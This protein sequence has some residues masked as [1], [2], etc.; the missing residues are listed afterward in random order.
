[1]ISNA[2]DHRDRAQG[3]AS[4]EER[5]AGAEEAQAAPRGAC[6]LAR[7]GGAARAAGVVEDDVP[8][9]RHGH[10]EGAAGG[11]VGGAGVGAGAAGAP[12]ASSREGDLYALPRASL[13][14]RRRR[15]WSTAACTAPASSPESS[16]RRSS[17]ACRCTGR[18]RPSTARACTSLA[19]RWSTCTTG[20]ASLIE[21]L[22]LT[23]AR[24]GAAEPHRLRRR[25][26]AQ[27][28]AGQEARLHLDLR[29]R[30]GRRLRLQPRRAGET[31]SR[32]LGDSEGVLVV[33]GYTGYNQVTLPGRRQRAGCNAHARRKFRDIEHP[34]ARSVIEHYKEVFAVERE[35][36]ERG[37]VGTPE[38]LEL[39]RA[40]A[41]PA[42][43][44]IRQIVDDQH[45]RHGPK[46]PMGKAIRYAR[47]QWEY[48]TRFLDDVAIEPS[49]NL[50]ERLLRTVA[51]GRKNYL[52]V[53]HE[54]AGPQHRHARLGRADMRPPRRRPRRPTS[55]TSSSASRR[56]PCPRST[57][58]CRIAGR[59]SSP[60][61]LGEGRKR[62]T[63]PELSPQDVVCRSDSE[64]PELRFRL[65]T[66]RLS[67]LQPGRRERLP[68]GSPRSFGRRSGA[69]SQPGGL[70][71]FSQH[72]VK[73]GDR[74]PHACSGKAASAVGEHGRHVGGGGVSGSERPPAALS[75][76]AWRVRPWLP[77]Q[78][79]AVP[80]SPRGWAPS[81]GSEQHVT[82]DKRHTR[83]QLEGSHPH[84]RGYVAYPGRVVR[85]DLFHDGRRFTRFGPEPPRHDAPKQATE[86]E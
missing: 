77:H 70:R 86:L 65:P 75:Q 80:W 76:T 58:S 6:G 42:M 1:M 51:L 5:R 23:D 84:C 72:R 19:R 69:G 79:G 68:P 62:R 20:P 12:G 50:S 7:G 8:G 60:T 43:E 26:V 41:G 14:Q 64:R 31:A 44:A 85:H 29:D 63:R 56:T 66:G 83:A 52:F 25:D 17:T 82:L 34:A 22:H 18:P 67:M 46:T 74:E 36:K 45:G 21:P 2:L 37:I 30:D 35:A 81:S 10:D 32:V 73:G 49:N 55:P 54:D 9:L 4:P 47:N 33:D 71:S 13:G 78:Q 39:R 15:G 53:G 48:L 40:R 16:Y 61:V 28:A 24:A 59:N 3:V 27:D 38:H 57:T 11:G